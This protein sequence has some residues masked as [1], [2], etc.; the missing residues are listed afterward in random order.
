MK[1]E[2]AKQLKDAGFDEHL[3][4]SPERAYGIVRHFP[5][6][7]FTPTLAELIEACM[8]YFREGE[9]LTITFNFLNS[10]VWQA[11]LETRAFGHGPTPEEAVA[12][13]W[14]AL[15]HNATP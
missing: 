8:T 2:L 12:R 10:G 15:H 9:L 3:K 1:Y 13:L 4:T 5:N 6:V 14:L 7:V 11:S